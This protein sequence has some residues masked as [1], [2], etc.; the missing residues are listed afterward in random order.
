VLTIKTK[1][2]LI[3]KISI[4]L[5][6][7]LAATY[8]YRGFLLPLLITFIFYY[9]SLSKLSENAGQLFT[10]DILG[11]Y[12]PALM[13]THSLISAHIF[14]GIDYSLF[15][16]SSDFFL[17]PNFFAVNPLV[18]L[19]SLIVPF[20][21]VTT[22]SSGHFLIYLLA[23]HSFV[24]FYFGLKLMTR[25][26]N[27][28]FAPALLVAIGYTFNVY[29]I[30]SSGQPP[31]LF[32]AALIPLIIY[33]T[34]LYC[35]KRTLRQLIWSSLPPLFCILSGYIPLSLF[36]LLLAGIVAAGQILYLD[37]KDISLEGKLSATLRIAPPFVIALLVTLPY[38]IEILRFNSLTL[39]AGQHDI[40]YSAHEYSEIPQTLIR[41]FSSNYLVPGPLTEFTVAW[42]FIPI[43]IY[44][45]FF[46]AKRE[47]KLN[48]YQWRI[49]KFSAI[50]YF[51]LLMAIFGIYSPASNLIYYFL[52]K[53]GKM[54]IYQ[55]FLLPAYFPFMLM[56]TMLFEGLI[57]RKP[58]EA[59][60]FALK[61]MILLTIISCLILTHSETL[62]KFGFCNELVFESFLTCLFL[63]AMLIPG[64]VFSY[65][66]MIVLLTLPYLNQQYLLSGDKNS[67]E[68]QKALVPM[69]V[70]SVQQ[71]QFL[72]YLERFK[73]K[74]IIKYVDISPF[75]DPHVRE[76][77]PKDFPYFVL[78]DKQLSSYNGFT[79][80]LSAIGEYFGTNMPMGEKITVQPN[81]EYLKNTG[82]DFVIVPLPLET[83]QGPLGDL[84]RKTK[85]E[86]RYQLPND[87]VAVPLEFSQNPTDPTTQKEIFNN[88]YFAVDS[89]NSTNTS[90][91][92]LDSFNTNNA[93]SMTFSFE[94]NV[95][96]VIH[97]LFWKNS[98]LTFFLNGKEIPVNSNNGLSDIPTPPG[99]NILEVRYHNKMLE[100]FWIVYAL[101][102][103]T[104]L[105]SLTPNTVSQKIRNLIFKN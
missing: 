30:N 96:T 14:S 10:G 37:T 64:R 5:V 67:F 98:H 88:G 44:C 63:G 85:P 68:K 26:F 86:S 49:F 22:Q 75:W 69:A 94:T 65:F 82:A 59:F 83:I 99:K 90:I 29:S 50:I 73:N 42:G 105:L 7:A 87:L 12:L 51:F 15:N 103:L 2:S 3:D 56:L 43:M 104:L 76:P 6:K 60:R 11:Y 100:L 36:C 34:L 21:K 57:Y 58:V 9:P 31:F 77:F 28:S 70:D 93:N 80:Y 16:G 78:K 41:I 47:N 79:F 45:C 92:N 54:H 84:L 23:F 48:D 20:N 52:P 71:Q 62:T 4:N 35:Q 91:F 24:C 39:S 89:T 55:R 61:A 74:K 97:Y 32:S 102:F 17:S 8:K 19:Y 38:L 25:F 27:L 46:L 13:K 53:L 72:S 33:S 18:V 101:Y 81:V 40:F 66:A 1:E 95:A